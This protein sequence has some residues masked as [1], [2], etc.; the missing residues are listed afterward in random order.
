M[1]CLSASRVA[2]IKAQIVIKEKQLDEAN[3]LYSKLLNNPNASYRFEDGEGAQ[4]VSTRKLT[5]VQKVI[6]SLESQ[7][8]RLYNQLSG[9]GLTRTT[10]NRIR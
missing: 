3:E 4:Q 5:D 2:R 6:D 8:N 7:L 10:L 9:R 1:S